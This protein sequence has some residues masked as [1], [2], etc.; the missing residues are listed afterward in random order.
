MSRIRRAPRAFGAESEAHRS[1]APALRL[2]VGYGLG[3]VPPVPVE[4]LRV[5]LAL[6]VHV[7][8]VGSVR[9]TA[10]PARA[11]SRSGRALF[12]THLGDVRAVRLLIAFGDGE[13]ALAGAHLDAVIRNAQPHR[14]SERLR[15]PL[16]RRTGIWINEDRD[17]R[18]GRNRAVNAALTT[19]QNAARSD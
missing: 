18:A 2:Y 13:A 8:S 1:P 11:R 15:Q 12:D 16:G 3:E 19:S 14:E 6:A 9:I 17:D 7:R 4:V 10:P 5:V